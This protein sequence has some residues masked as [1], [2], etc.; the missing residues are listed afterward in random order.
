LGH[1]NASLGVLLMWL[2][3]GALI[4]AGL[5]ILVVW[6]RSHKIKIGWYQS[7]IAALGLL[8][9]LFAIE[10]ARTS[11]SEFERIAAAKTL[12][13]FG[14]PGVL[15]ILLSAALVWRKAAKRAS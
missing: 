10:N 9:V 13:V 5:S 12:L 11:F 8:L 14:A 6:L 4:G 2:I 1:G 15:L 3:L 7:V